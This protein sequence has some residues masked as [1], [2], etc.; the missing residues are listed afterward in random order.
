MSALTH[1]SKLETTEVHDILN[2][3]RRRATI[4]YLRETVGP[5]SLRRLSEAVAER[6]CG[7]SPPPRDLRASVYN[8]LHQ[9]H[10]PKL[11]E[12]DVVDYDADRKTIAVDERASEVYVH[13]EVV[14]R[15]GITWAAYYRSLGVLGLLAVVA[16]EFGVAVLADAGPAPIAG[17]F[18]ALF[19]L[20]TAKQLWCNRWRYVDSIFGN[21][22]STDA[23]ADAAADAN[24]DAR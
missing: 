23:A 14:S 17:V 12:C 5:V 24:I 10:L 21:R 22:S 7:E 15:Y 8:S 6:E 19:A 11:D 2:N 20:S 18:L 4:E 1:D 16:S 13:M 3:D 9:T